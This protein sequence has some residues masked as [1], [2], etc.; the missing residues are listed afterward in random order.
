MIAIVSDLH[1]QLSALSRLQALHR[2]ACAV[3]LAS[4]PS[5]LSGLTAATF[6]SSPCRAAGVWPATDAQRLWAAPA[7]VEEGTAMA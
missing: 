3:A 2:S 6:P 5:Q 1:H 7:E 4:S